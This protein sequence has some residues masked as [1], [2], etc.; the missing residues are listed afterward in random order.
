VEDFGLFEA[1]VAGARR[2][3][4]GVEAG[5]LIEG[6]H[7]ARVPVAKDVA[8]LAAVVATDEV[9]EGALA[10]WIVAHGGL[11]VGLRFCN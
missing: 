1:V 6:Q 4:T 7:G 10:G 2:T 3:G 8:T 9:V 11:D 5:I